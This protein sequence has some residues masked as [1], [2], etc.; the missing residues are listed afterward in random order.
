VRIRFTDSPRAQFLAAVAYIFEDR[1]TAAVSLRKCAESLLRHLG[2][3]PE[4]GRAIPECPE[5][6]YR[7]VLVPPL[8]FFYLVKGGTI[9]I[10]AVWHSALVPRKSLE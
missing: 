6:P 1:P 5:L 10:V 4:S 8:R 9:W 7:E 3:L 2:E